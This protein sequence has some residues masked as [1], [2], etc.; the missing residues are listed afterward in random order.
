MLIKPDD[1][2]VIRKVLAD[3]KYPHRCRLCNFPL[4]TY[5]DTGEL[6]ECFV[7][8]TAILRTGTNVDTNDLGQTEGQADRH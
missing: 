1:V 6:V 5:R 4:F 3:P 7:M 2:D 8:L